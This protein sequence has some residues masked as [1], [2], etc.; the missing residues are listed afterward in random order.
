LGGLHAQRVGD[1]RSS[2]FDG[3]DRFKGS[4]GVY[5]PEWAIPTEAF[6]QIEQTS[7]K[8]NFCSEEALAGQQACGSYQFHSET[9]P[10]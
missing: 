1:C 9:I 2:R 3:S 10:N 8:V 4:P 6:W 7:G 5:K